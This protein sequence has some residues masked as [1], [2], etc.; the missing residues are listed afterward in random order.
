MLHLLAF[1][2]ASAGGVALEDV[3]GVQDNWAALNAANHYLLPIEMQIKAAYVL[4]P[5]ATQ[6]QISTP[7][8]RQVALP[9]IAPMDIGTAPTSLAAVDWYN[10]PFN[11]LKQNDELTT[12]QSDNAGAGIQK[13]SALVLQDRMNLN[14]PQGQI[15]TLRGTA[16]GTSGNKVWGATTFQFDQTIPYG[17]YA[18]I[19]LDVVGANLIFARLIFPS[20]GPRPGVIARQ[21]EAIKPD[22]RFRMGALGEWG[23]FVTTSPP[24]LEL[25]GSAAP[26]TQTMYMDVIKVA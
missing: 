26:T 20:G 19:G 14:I 1:T 4:S 2:K 24:S 9:A 13:Y 15:Y 23:R 16:S 11:V 12:L 25:F 22:M 21:T 17:Q 10:P 18:V 7:N 8:L 6:A 5:N 3:P